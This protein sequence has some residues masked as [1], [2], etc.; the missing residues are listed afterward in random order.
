MAT[1]FQYIW[2]AYSICGALLSIAFCIY[3]TWDRLV[4]GRY[5][6]WLSVASRILIIAS[7]WPLA[8]VAYIAMQFDGGDS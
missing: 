8:L 5:W 7:L 3:V 4:N 6:G 2:I 1:A